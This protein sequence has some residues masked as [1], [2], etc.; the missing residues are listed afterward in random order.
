MRRYPR[1]SG[2]GEESIKNLGRRL[3]AGLLAT[4]L[5]TKASTR[6]LNEASEE[7][8]P[9]WLDLADMFA[10]CGMGHSPAVLGGKTPNTIL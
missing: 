4:Q 5:V 10:Q 8:G 2:I 7:V 1:A 3:A 9:F 6:V